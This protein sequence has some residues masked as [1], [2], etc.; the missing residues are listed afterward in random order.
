MSSH[1]NHGN[2]DCCKPWET[3][4]LGCMR[5]SEKVGKLTKRSGECSRSVPGNFAKFHN[6]RKSK[7][8]LFM[9]SGYLESHLRLDLCPK[10]ILESLRGGPL[11]PQKWSLVS[12]VVPKWKWWSTPHLHPSSPSPPQPTTPLELAN[13]GKNGQD[14]HDKTIEIGLVEIPSS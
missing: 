9:I 12:L 7:H 1:E 13:S 10:L 3:M 11:L 5:F 6:K 8:H 2:H 4:K 14:A